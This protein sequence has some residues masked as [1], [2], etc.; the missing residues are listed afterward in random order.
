MAG[1]PRDPELEKRLLAATWALLTRDGYDDLTFAKVAEQA[2][3]HRT[4]LYRRWPSKV[5]LVTAAVDVHQPPLRDV[6]AGS[7]HR[8][9]RA[10]LDSIEER[11]TSASA[12]GIVAWIADLHRDP[13]AAVAHREMSV[14][15]SAP[16]AKV[17]DR[18]VARGEIDP[19]MND[20]VL[21]GHLL[22]GPVMHSHVFARRPMIAVE[23]DMVAEVT[24]RLLAGAEQG[25]R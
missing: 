16:L 10:I 20:R 14:R 12:D 21:V 24:C 9:L 1:R 19:S 18:A 7:L 22:E 11:W 6:D 8:D 5:Q 23:L 13:D 4:D 2:G 15:G 25:A 3:A 17:L